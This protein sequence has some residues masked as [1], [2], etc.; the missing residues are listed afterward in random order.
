MKTELKIIAV[1]TVISTFII[2][3]IVSIKNNTNSEIE[4]S[5]NG[6][7]VLLSNNILLKDT[8]KLETKVETKEEDVQEEIVQEEVEV[9]PQQEVENSTNE[10]DENIEEQEV[11]PV[12]VFDGLTK[13]ELVNKLNRNLNS[14]LSGTGEIFANY[15]IEYGID[16]YLAVAIVLHETGCSWNCS[17]LVNQCYNVGGQKGA[18]GC[19]GGAYQQFSSLE[20]GISSFM[21]NLYRNYYSVGLTTAETINSKYAANPTWYVSINNYINKIKAS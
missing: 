21:S 19:W 14:T 11:E 9:A 17:E 12:I 6:N 2:G 20:E 5:K 10:V 1:I 13:E 3:L 18:P 8:T 4:T 15:A 7:E 16:P